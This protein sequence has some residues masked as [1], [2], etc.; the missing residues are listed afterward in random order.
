[1]L[2]SYKNGMRDQNIEN[3]K[4]KNYNS[5]QQKKRILNFIAIQM[6]L[7]DFFHTLFN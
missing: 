7:G 5:Q 3:H 4:L 1:M 6:L 2:K